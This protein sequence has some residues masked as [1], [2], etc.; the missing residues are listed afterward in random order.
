MWVSRPKSSFDIYCNGW[1][2]L[3][4]LTIY[5][6]I[7]LADKTDSGDEISSPSHV[8]DTEWESYTCRY[9]WP[10]QG[11]WPSATYENTGKCKKKDN[12]L[13]PICVHQSCNNLLAVGTNNGDVRLYQYPAISKNVSFQS[14]HGHVSQVANCRFNCDGTYLITLGRFDRCIAVWKVN[15]ENTAFET[16]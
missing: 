11:I 16:K 6:F 14:E 5:H 8:K 12:S 9:G 13:E 1:Q 2:Y 3:F 4:P 7:T 15:K 10:V